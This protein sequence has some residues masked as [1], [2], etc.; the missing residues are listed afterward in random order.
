MCYF[1]VITFKKNL[2]VENDC[3][4]KWCFPWYL[5][6]WFSIWMQS[7]MYESEAIITWNQQ[8]EVHLLVI[9]DKDS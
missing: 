3:I 5:V 6:F 7:N 9:E 8:N 1:L 4:R 2:K